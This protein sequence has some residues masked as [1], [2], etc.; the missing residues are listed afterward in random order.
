M[1][2]SLDVFLDAPAAAVDADVAVGG[3]VQ[4]LGVVVV[5]NGGGLVFEGGGGG[6]EDDDT[7]A[8]AFAGRN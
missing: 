6:G 7:S 1:Y 5:A 2:R 3:L 8:E 4:L